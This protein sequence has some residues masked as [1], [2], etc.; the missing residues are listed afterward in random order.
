MGNLSPEQK[1]KIRL[2]QRTKYK[3]YKISKIDEPRSEISLNGDWL[4]KPDYEV[5][6]NSNCY[7]VTKASIF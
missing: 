7:T 3:P 4:F 2:A 6:Q 1:E 5:F